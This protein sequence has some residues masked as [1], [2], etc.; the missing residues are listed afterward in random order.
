[1]GGDPA[2]PKGDLSFEKAEFA[3]GES[4]QAAECSSCKQPLVGSYYVVGG[5]PSCERC[6][7]QYELDQASAAGSGRFLRALV[8][9]LGAAAA[10]S[11]IWYA[12]RI[13]TEYEVGLIAVVVG[14]MVGG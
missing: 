6:K 12:V 5:Q 1:M 14:L 11:A 8:F 7:T 3:S 4:P 2:G 9:G 13:T 10:G